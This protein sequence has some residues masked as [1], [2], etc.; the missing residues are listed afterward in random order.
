EYFISHRLDALVFP[1]TPLPAARIGDDVSVE[2]NGEQVA[3]FATFARNTNPGSVAGL[4]GISIPAGLSGGLPVGLELDGPWQS[5]RQLL[6][7]AQAIE[8]QQEPLP[9]P[10]FLGEEAFN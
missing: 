7:I 1:T 4:P 9:E 10:Q 6:A 2:H 5:D 8:A 3:T